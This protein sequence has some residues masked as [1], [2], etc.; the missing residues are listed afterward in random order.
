MADITKLQN[1]ENTG[2]FLE[3]SK[4]PIEWKG[5]NKEMKSLTHEYVEKVRIE[6]ERRDESIIESKASDVTDQILHAN[7]SV[8]SF[9]LFIGEDRY[10]EIFRKR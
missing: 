4:K 5:Y 2:K 3:N 1:H 8:K 9:G 10:N 6:K 7:G